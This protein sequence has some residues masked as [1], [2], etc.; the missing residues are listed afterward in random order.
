MPIKRINPCGKR[1]WLLRNNTMAAANTI[2]YS[3]LVD[4]YSRMAPAFVQN[5][6]WLVAVDAVP[7][8][9]AVTDTGN[10]LIWSPGMA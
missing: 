3:D 1:Q 9:M 10:H 5:A 6:I 2:G 4:I 7:K 8:L